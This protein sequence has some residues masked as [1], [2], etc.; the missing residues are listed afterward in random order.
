MLWKLQH[1]VCWY[2]K[3]RETDKFDKIFEQNN[4]YLRNLSTLQSNEKSDAEN[5][6]SSQDA[7]GVKPGKSTENSV[8]EKEEETKPKEA[9]KEETDGP[10][11]K[12]ENDKAAT[13]SKEE[14]KPAKKVE[15]KDNDESKQEIEEEENSE[16]DGEES[17]KEDGDKE[18]PLLDQ[19]LEKSGKRERKNVQRFNE[20][21][22]SDSKDVSNYILN[23]ITVTWYN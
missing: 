1:G 17:D 18:V 5:T 16:K 11:K 14:T 22:S 9:P 8:S 15:K 2:L 23:T 21:F 7:K 10:D 19:P 13:N 3:K 4:R 12:P 20:E 6:D